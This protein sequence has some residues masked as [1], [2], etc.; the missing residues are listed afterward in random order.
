MV[1]LL[2]AR[3][4][5]CWARNV[6]DSSPFHVAASAGKHEIC[7][8]L[9]EAG[10]TDY[11]AKDSEGTVSSFHEYPA[12]AL[13]C[14]AACTGHTPIELAIASGYKDLASK[15]ALWSSIQ[16]SAEVRYSK[17]CSSKWS[18]LLFYR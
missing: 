12:T 5:D 15:I 14:F 17:F 11:F 13:F 8:L 1:Q 10:Y 7:R 16:L 9:S 4:A 18:F 6:N 2:L 3:G